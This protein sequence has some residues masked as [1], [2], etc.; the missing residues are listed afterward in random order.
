VGAGL[1]GVAKSRVGMGLAIGAGRALPRVVG[2]RVVNA[3]SHRISSR[4]SDVVRAVR[5][6]QWVVSGGVLDGSELEEA[7]RMTFESIGRCLYDYY[8]NLNDPVALEEMVEIDRTLSARLDSWVEGDSGV[9]FVGAHLANPELLLR[10]MANRGLKVQA[11]SLPRPDEGRRRENELREDAGVEVT[12]ISPSA[13]RQAV[14]R[15]ESGG[16]VLTGIDFPVPGSK[17]KLTFFGRDTSLPTVHIRLALKTGAP[18]VVLHC[19]S[20]QDG[21]YRMLASE[22]IHMDVEGDR[23]TRIRTNGE[24]LLK[25]IEGPIRKCPT[26]WCMTHPVWPEAYKELTEQRGPDGGDR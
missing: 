6:N 23:R 15:L 3:V 24:Q 14:N 19:E 25:E 7:V 4:E 9:I 22:P 18:I 1:L 13:L 26:Q 20:T 10:V 5:A 12:P 17:E 2:R 16:H 8:H 21:R 11:L